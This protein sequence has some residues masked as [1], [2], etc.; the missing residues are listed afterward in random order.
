MHVAALGLSPL[1]GG[2]AHHPDRLLLAAHGVV[3]DRRFCCVDPAARRV[4]RTVENPAL[5]AL[6][7]Q[8]HDPGTGPSTDPGTALTL[9]V[10]GRAP[11]T[12]PVVP[13]GRLRADYWGR[14]P[15]LTLLDG[16]WADLL[17]AH[18]GRRVVLAEAAPRDVVYA[19]GVTVVTTSS[20]REVA[21]RAG[22]DPAP[23]DLLADAERWRANVVVDTGDAPAFVE[24]AW[25]GGSLRLGGAR[26]Q[27]RAG[28]PRCAVVRLRPRHGAREGWDPLGLLVPDRLR[29]QEVVFGLDAEVQQPGDM[30]VGAPVEV[31]VG[32]PGEAG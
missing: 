23:D 28:V 30:A 15:E 32:A 6:R 4:L 10:P 8:V 31:A 20:L 12:A 25:V 29:D 11:V 2:S 1:K 27:V 17:S 3:G 14:E 19:G 9:H 26:L 16:P 5:L 21:R 18:L 22:L 13:A 7:V 24:D